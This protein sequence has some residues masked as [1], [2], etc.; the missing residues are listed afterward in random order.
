MPSLQAYL[1]PR[2]R[3]KIQQRGM[4]FSEYFYRYCAGRK[5]GIFGSKYY[6][7]AD[8][9][10]VADLD[11]VMRFEN[12]QES[13]RSVLESL[14]VAYQGEVPRRNKT[15]KKNDNLQYYYPPAI[16]RDCETYLNT[17]MTQLGYEYP[18]WWLNS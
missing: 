7:I 12:F 6:D 10:C 16:R 2:R 3:R 8:R 11:M 9:W 1:A 18:E 15:K 17:A 14:D 13:L 4:D 5:L